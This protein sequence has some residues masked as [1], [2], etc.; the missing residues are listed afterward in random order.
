MGSSVIDNGEWV[1]VGP[2]TDF[3]LGLFASAK[4][5]LQF[6]YWQKPQAIATKIKLLL[7]L[8]KKKKGNAN[9]VFWL[10]FDRLYVDD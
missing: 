6:K 10:P 9:F 3:G 2:G 5:Y 1:P 7:M 8:Q 4:E